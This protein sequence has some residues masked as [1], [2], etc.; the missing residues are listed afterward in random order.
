MESEEKEKAAYVQQKSV[1]V[2][3]VSK[4][5]NQKFITP[6]DFIEQRPKV[7]IIDGVL[8]KSLNS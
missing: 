8:S 4:L 5:K 2:T 1:Y 3:D 6:L 7:G